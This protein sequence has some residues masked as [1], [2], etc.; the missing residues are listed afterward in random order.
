MGNLVG[1][2]TVL[3]AVSQVSPIK[4]YFPISEQEYLR[5][6][7][8]GVPGNV[9]FITHASRIALR[10][11][12]DD[13]SVYPHRGRIIFANQQVKPADRNHS[14]RGRVPR[15]P[16]IC[17]GGPVRARVPGAHRKH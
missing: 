17:C 16:E 14:D 12:C 10:F 8:G 2:S 4:V 6:A 3:T 15:T 5:M 1:A 13:G 11:I 7:D 9:D